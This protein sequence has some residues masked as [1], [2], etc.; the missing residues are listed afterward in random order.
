MGKM[1]YDFETDR[2]ENYEDKIA[3][4]KSI[5]GSWPPPFDPV[6]AVQVSQGRCG[7]NGLWRIVDSFFEGAT[8]EPRFEEL[9]DVR[10]NKGRNWIPEARKIYLYYNVH[11]I[12]ANRLHFPILIW[13][14]QNSPKIVH[15]TREDHLTR[16]ISIFYANILTDIRLADDKGITPYRRSEIYSSPIDFNELDKL[17]KISYLE[18]ETIKSLIS[19]YVS[20]DQ[21]LRISHADVFHSNVPN[22]LRPYC[23]VP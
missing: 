3:E 20:E 11:A 22:T 4:L 23:P 5:F 19:E 16:A 17:F 13:L 10:I 6:W 12:S 7:S 14:L 1:N 2:Y 18:I 21:L 9:D 15:L 8:T